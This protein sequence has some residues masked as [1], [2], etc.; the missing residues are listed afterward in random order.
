MTQTSDYV[1]AL[2]KECRDSLRNPASTTYCPPSYKIEAPSAPAQGV[3]RAE[4]A[5]PRLSARNPAWPLPVTL[6]WR[7]GPVPWVCVGARGGSLLLPGHLTIAEVV[8]R[9]N[10]RG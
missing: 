8:L 6:A 9:L 7:N 4:G 3:Q 1:A 5:R 2:I 10:G